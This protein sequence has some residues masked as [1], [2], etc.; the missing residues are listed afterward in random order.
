MLGLKLNHVITLGSLVVCILW[1][2]VYLWNTYQVS[3]LCTKYQISND[4]LILTHDW[5]SLPRTHHHWQVLGVTWWSSAH[6]WQHHTS[7]CYW[8]IAMGIHRLLVIC[9]H[10][11]EIFIIG[12]TENCQNDNFRCSQSWKFQDDHIFVSVVVEIVPVGG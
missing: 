4:I 10:L 6:Y 2:N 8:R 1:I 12:C 5:Y 9:R 7:F 3:I 11:G